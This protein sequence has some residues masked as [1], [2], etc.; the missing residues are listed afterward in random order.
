MARVSEARRAL[1]RLSSSKRLAQRAGR[2]VAYG[3]RRPFSPSW[4]PCITFSWSQRRG[5]DVHAFCAA[6]RFHR[7]VRGAPAQRQALIRRPLGR[8]ASRRWR[9]GPARWYGLFDGETLP[10]GFVF[11]RNEWVQ[12]WSAGSLLFEVRGAFLVVMFHDIPWGST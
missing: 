6:Y 3:S 2:R 9:G 4:A 8:G 12:V 11:A 5:Q 1:P 10:I 7:Y